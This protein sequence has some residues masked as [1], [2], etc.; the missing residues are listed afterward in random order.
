MECS[1]VTLTL[2]LADHRST[3]VLQGIGYSKEEVQ[4]I[5]GT[6]GDQE[7][8]DKLLL[9]DAKIGIQLNIALQQLKEKSPSGEVAIATLPELKLK[10]DSIR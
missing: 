6:G 5:A 2:I 3:E 7:R 4:A 9:K 10:D 1:A 8:I